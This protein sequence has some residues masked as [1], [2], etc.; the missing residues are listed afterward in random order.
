MDGVIYI[1]MDDIINVSFN[2]CMLTYMYEWHH[3]CAVSYHSP[4]LERK[5]L[6][7]ILVLL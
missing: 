1:Y 7:P 5:H 6:T 4:R 3:I 2:G